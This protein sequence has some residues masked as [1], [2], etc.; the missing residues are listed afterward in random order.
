MKITRLYD[1]H[2][3]S[4]SPVARLFHDKHGYIRAVVIKEDGF[5]LTFT[6]PDSA[7]A[8]GHSYR[9]AAIAARAETEK[10]NKL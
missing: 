3:P 8:S 1:G 6:E 2:P 10:W 4:G 9:N 7:Q 5:Y